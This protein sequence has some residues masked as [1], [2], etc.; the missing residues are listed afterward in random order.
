MMWTR[1]AAATMAEAHA[2]EEACDAKRAREWLGRE[3]VDSELTGSRLTKLF[4]LYRGPRCWNLKILIG[5][6][7]G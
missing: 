5:G 2:R 7:R 4:E 1:R 6:R 3:E